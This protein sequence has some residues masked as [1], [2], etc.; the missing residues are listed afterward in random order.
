MEESLLSKIMLGE[1]KKLE[2][3]NFKKNML[4]KL[5]QVI[6][7]IVPH[8][9]IRYIKNKILSVNLFI[10]DLEIKKR[11]KYDIFEYRKLSADMNLYTKEYGYNGFYGLADIVKKVLG[12]PDEEVL[13]GAIE[14]GIVLGNGLTE[15]DTKPD[16]IYAFGIKRKLFLEQIFKK[17][18]IYSLGPYIQ[19]VDSF[20]S[21]Q[22]L[23]TIKDTLGKT[24]LVFHSHSTPHIRAQFEV[25]EF[26]QEIDRIKKAKE[27]K[28]VLVCMYW[29]DVLNGLDE[30][31]LMAGY[32]ICTAGHMFDKNFLNRLKSII[33]LSD[34][35]IGNDIGTHVGYCI[36]VG[37]PYYL[38]LKL[39][40]YVDFDNNGDYLE[41]NNDFFKQLLNDGIE[42]F[43]QYK[44]YISDNDIKFVEEYWGKWKK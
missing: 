13:N 17:K 39:P 32:K 12:I 8:K 26:I 43:G 20:Y 5:K 34:V 36:S 7:M 19:Y 30:K 21:F 11:E 37:I 23:K 38:Y 14:H 28:T 10:Y 41:F 6:K 1:Y 40:D 2:S 33:L 31:F 42:C 24:L 27:F 25:D 18:H 15:V 35:A 16:I 9:I 29:K 44:E 22:E 4:D 3:K